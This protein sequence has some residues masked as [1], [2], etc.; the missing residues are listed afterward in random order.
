MLAMAGMPAVYF[1]SLVGTQNDLEGARASG[2]AR[3]I[4]RRKFE[5]AE[6]MQ[7]LRERESLQDRIYRGYRRL[8]SC[9]IRQP[10]FHP[11][12]A[13]AVIDLG[14]P[15]VIAFLRASI[16]GL[17]QILVAANLS[18]EPKC[19]NLPGDRPLFGGSDLLGNATV[20]D[21]GE[22]LL[23]AFGVAWLLVG[24]GR[25]FGDNAIARS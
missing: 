5:Y 3:R 7:R 22:I 1:H 15:Q 13:Q 10:A 23:P 17:Q 9:R 11:A 12:A 4:N 18:Q 14:D 21:R 25:E 19:L 8:L 24:S 16:D 6:L 2:H 20:S